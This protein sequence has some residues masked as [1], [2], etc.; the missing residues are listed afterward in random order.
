MPEDIKLIDTYSFSEGKEF[1]I[2]QAVDDLVRGYDNRKQT[3]IDNLTDLLTKLF[4]VLAE[5]D[6]LDRGDIIWVINPGRFK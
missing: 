6:I 2:S 1:T 5:K 4:T 3:Q